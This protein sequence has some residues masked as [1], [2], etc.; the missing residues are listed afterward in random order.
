MS[1]VSFFFI[2]L[3]FRSVKKPCQNSFPML[4]PFYHPALC[5]A[6]PLGIHLS[7]SHCIT[8]L[9]VVQSKVQQTKV[10]F[11]SSIFFWYG[12]N[13]H[14]GRNHFCRGQHFLPRAYPVHMTS[15]LE[16][17]QHI[18]LFCRNQLYRIPMRNSKRALDVRCK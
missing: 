7:D 9:T 10:L 5:A 6:Q 2:G 3:R 1:F 16:T 11:L 18:N 15:H 8:F 14:G 13:V 4:F 17:I 12:L